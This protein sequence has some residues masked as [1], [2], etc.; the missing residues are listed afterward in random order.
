ML[1]TINCPSCGATNQLPE[2]KTSMFCAFC[3]SAIKAAEKENKLSS[4]SSI[5]TKPEISK[6][7]TG[8]GTEYVAKFEWDEF[9]TLVNKGTYKETEVILDKGGELSLIDRN[10]KSLDEISVWFSDN[11]LNEIQTL[12]L[13]KNKI[14]SLKGI[15]R[16]QSLK[17][18]SICKNEIHELPKENSYLKNLFRIYLY[19]NPVEQNIS[20]NDLNYYSNIRFYIPK[21][22]KINP[23]PN[24]V[25]DMV[26]SYEN[27]NIST[28]EEIV[29]LYST[30]ELYEIEEIN[31]ANNNIKTLKGLSK[32]NSYVIDFSNNDLIL[33]DELP[34]FRDNR[35]STI[36]ANIELNFYNNKNLKEFTDNVTPQFYNVKIGKITIFLSGCKNFNYESLDR[37]NFNRIF[38]STDSEY[39]YFR[40]YQSDANVIMPTSLKKIGFINEGTFW[41]LPKKGNPSYKKSGC[42]IATATMGCY[43]HPTVMELRYFRD[44]WILQKS[45]GEG[46]V[47]WYYHYGA[48][49]AKD[50]EKS[51]VL[52][53]IS[54]LLI[55]KPLVYLA[56]IVKK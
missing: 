25:G 37:I 22:K 32:F 21:I 31:F 34:K 33:I 26:L 18:L 20:Q 27:Q 15:E 11:E 51:F 53:K 39:S 41:T 40:V 10:I 3:G 29:D 28:V 35:H 52:K 54:Y 8:K 4:Q 1:Q 48:I 2:G 56:R 23:I 16:F 24:F 17:T 14:N 36:G 5:I 42:F 12:N 44:N 46:F 30:D 55:V 47:K 7:K 6:K 50:I 49:A 19:G 13:N 9:N 43:E 38:N 45:W